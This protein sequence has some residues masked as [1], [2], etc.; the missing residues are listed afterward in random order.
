MALLA[1]TRK[2]VERKLKKSC[3]EKVPAYMLRQL[4]LGFKI[5]GKSVTLFEERPS[6]LIMVLVESRPGVTLGV[7]PTNC[8]SISFA[9]PPNYIPIKG[10]LLRW[11]RLDA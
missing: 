4:R 2:L 10:I 6:Y 7:Q 9:V 1:L 5:R 3:D 8:C 11:E